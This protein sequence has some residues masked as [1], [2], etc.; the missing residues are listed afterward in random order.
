MKL[1]GTEFVWQIKDQGR[2]DVIV[3]T[4]AVRDSVKRLAE[5]KPERAPAAPMGFESL[6]DFS[7]TV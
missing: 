2:Q 4:P 3:L 6:V 1:T 7:H 5:V